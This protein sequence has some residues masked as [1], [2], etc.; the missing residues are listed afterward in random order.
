MPGFNG[1]AG[2]AGDPG[3]FVDLPLRQYCSAGL[4]ARDPEIYGQLTERQASTYPDRNKGWMVYV[5][6]FCL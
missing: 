1:N 3:G 5:D 2:V 4:V 6:P